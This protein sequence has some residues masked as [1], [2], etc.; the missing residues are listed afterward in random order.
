MSPAARRRDGDGTLYRRES[1]L[2]VGSIDL[3]VGADGKRRR[4]SVSSTDKATAIGKLNTLRRQVE[5]GAIAVSPTAK[6]GDWFERWLVD[7][8]RPRLKPRT[9]ASYR[10]IIDGH[11]VPLLGSRTLAKL[12]PADVRK[13]HR[14]LAE[15]GLAPSTVMKTHRVLVKSLSDA[16]REGMVTRN[17]ASMV[18]APRISDSDRGA[19]SVEQAVALLR[20]S[21]D[22]AD[23]MTT[24]WAAALLLGARQGELLGLTWSRVDLDR[25]SIDLAW[26][27]QALPI[28]HGCGD[29]CG[30]VRAGWCPARALDVP[31]GFEHH[32][33][34][35][36]AL[37]LTRPK[38]R[39][40]R[41]LVP[42]PAP[43]A[44]LLLRHRDDATRVPGQHDLVWTTAAGAPIR[45]EADHAAWKAAL[46]TAGLPAVPLHAARHT[47]ATLLLEAGVDA[48]VIASI[49]GHSE[50]VT[51]R[52]YQHV[53]LSL[54]RAGM[55]NLDRLLGGPTASASDALE[56]AHQ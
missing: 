49:L 12:A 3:G 20:T 15:R 45:P 52:G 41:R 56:P 53:D 32:Q 46:H 40:G 14:T 31:T 43:L 21:D 33:L 27:L 13:M 35:S 38:S 16:V 11:L 23:P 8:A 54:A 26:Q 51:T 18:D 4:R 34:G 50:I 37:A 29:T 44:A 28:R 2:W 7:I 25:G 47:T 30:K 39:A 10:S 17:V 6:A 19:L 5:A 42:L 48:H 55:A 22:A 1:G 36:T 9:F 24:R